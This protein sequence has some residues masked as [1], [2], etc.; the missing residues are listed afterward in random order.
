[1]AKVTRFQIFTKG[2]FDKNL[3]EP[4]GRIPASISEP[5]SGAAGPRSGAPYAGN[6]RFKD[7]EVERPE[8]FFGED[9][10]WAD[11]E[12][13]A[14]PR[15]SAPSGRA[16]AAARLPTL[17]AELDGAYAARQ[18]EFFDRP[19]AGIAA[20]LKQARRKVE[21]S[22]ARMVIGKGGIE[23]FIV[24]GRGPAISIAACR[25]TTPLLV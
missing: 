13:T 16:F 19:V 23:G 18:A 9:R 15:L 5:S 17:A 10:I 1:L 8:T 6:R 7:L 11:S 25:A 4:G 12:R 2:L 24:G 14:T 20:R 21:I 22:P 3:L